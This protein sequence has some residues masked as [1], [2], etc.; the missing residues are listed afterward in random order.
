MPVL[1]YNIGWRQ[2]FIGQAAAV[3]TLSMGLMLILAF[4]ILGRHE[5]RE[6]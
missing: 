5:E 4:V 3:V 6:E 2:G 1:A